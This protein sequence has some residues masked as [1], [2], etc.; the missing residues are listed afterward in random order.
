MNKFNMQNVVVWIKSNRGNN[1]RYRG[2]NP[3][4]ENYLKLQVENSLQL[5]WDKKDLIFITNF[6]FEYMGV[7]SFEVNEICSWSSFVNKLFVVDKMIK[8]GVINDNFWL[9]DADAYQLVSFNFP[10][11]CKNVGFTRHAPRRNKP[12]GGS[13]FYRKEAFEMISVIA[14]L[15]AFFRPQKEELFFPLFYQKDSKGKLKSK[16]D[17]KL[18]ECQKKLSLSANDKERSKYSDLISF[19]SKG[20][21]YSEKHFGGYANAFSWL[22]WTYDLF[23]VKHFDIKY[24]AASKPIKVLHFHPEYKSC[25]DC[26][27]LGKNR[28]K[29]IPVTK[30][31]MNLFEKY[32][33]SGKDFEK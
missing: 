6:P 9:H 32:G 24:A 23:R 8:N 28:H 15:I 30:K 4:A 3:T 20:I 25:Y 26:F 12:Q 17:R 29:I 7:R 19:F 16:Y 1:F 13:S 33:F 31:L 27:C 5:G 21:E 2:E 14:Q 11:E 10:E 18:K 22:D